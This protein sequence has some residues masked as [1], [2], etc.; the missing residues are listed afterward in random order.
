MATSRSRSRRRAP[1]SSGGSPTA[2]QDEA[3]IVAEVGA[4]HD[5]ESGELVADEAKIREVGAID[6]STVIENERLQAIVNRKKA[7]EKKV[8]FNADDLLTE[9]ETLIKVWPVNTFDISVKRLTGSA[10]EHV[11]TSRPR[12]G[13][14]LYNTLM[15]MHGQFE[16]AKYA[17]KFFD[18]AG[19]PIWRVKNGKS[20]TGSFPG[21]RACCAFSQGRIYHLNAHGRLACLDATDG[22]ELWA[23]NILERFD[24]KNILWALSECLLIDGQRLIVSPGGKKALVAA[25]DKQTGKTVW[26]TDPLGDDHAA[27]ASPIL[28]RH[29]SR[30]VLA[31]CSS[32]HGLGIDANSG[33]LLWSVPLANR[34][35]TNISTPIYGW[36]QVF[37]VTPYTALGRAYRLVA[38]D[39]GIDARHLWTHPIDTVTGS[40]LLIGRTLF[41]SGYNKLKWWSLIDWQSGQTKQEIKDLST[42]AAIMADSRVYLLDERGN[43]A[44]LKLEPPPDGMEIVS[45]FRLPTDRKRVKDAW[46][47]PVLCDGRLY[48]RYHDKLWCYDVKRGGRSSR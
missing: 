48:I 39:Q 30:R 3:D 28:F 44:L 33:E 19:K 24:A 17:I 11:I 7:G 10:L 47:H 34:F 20:W 1:A 23:F 12:T 25:L 8:I 36:G 40:G 43:V 26:T 18:T 46:A 27:H 45:R 21:A 41:A 32:A 22:K 5:E 29:A 2:Q 37:Y 4:E 42:G 35:G 13:A 16:E 31:Q 38:N 15:A 14:E 9:Y 6:A